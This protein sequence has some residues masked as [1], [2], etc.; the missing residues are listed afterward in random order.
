MNGIQVYPH[1]LEHP[2]V[3]GFLR[4]LVES[5]HDPLNRMLF[6]DWL[7]E[8]GY[9]NAATGQR[10]AAKEKRAPFNDMGKGSFDDD[11]SNPSNGWYLGPRDL[12][13]YNYEYNESLL[14]PAFF[15]AH[16][17]L[18]TSYISPIHPEH[19][20]TNPDS[21]MGLVPESDDPMLE[22]ERNFLSASHKAAY[23]LNGDPI[24]THRTNVPH[25]DQGE[26]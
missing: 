11:P 17:R 12:S 3:E 18:H 2:E 21:V 24:G 23:S 25:N 26:A 13:N 4:G 20:R 16:Q 19:M 1:P 8:H 9:N 7:E 14:P 5:K 6:A 22:H 15:N 10:W